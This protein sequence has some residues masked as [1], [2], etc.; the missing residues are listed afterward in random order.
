M[1]NPKSGT[2]TMNV[3]QTIKELKAGRVEY[4]VD[5]Y[6]IIHV[7]VGKASFSA[8]KIAGNART[9]LEALT[10]AKPAASKGV[11]MMSIA[12]SSTMGPGIKVDHNT[13][14]SA[15]A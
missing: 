2:V 6:G 12:L 10:K 7:P 5:D 15:A 9:V 11:Y 3:A 8:D 13:K 1:P 4:K 14:Y